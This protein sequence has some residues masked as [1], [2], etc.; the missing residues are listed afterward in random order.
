MRGQ[1]Q[2]KFNPM[3]GC[4]CHVS[5]PESKAI[6]ILSFSSLFCVGGGVHCAFR[7]WEKGVFIGEV[8]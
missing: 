1:V 2:Q 7:Q 5:L 8:L 4:F 6:F 3:K